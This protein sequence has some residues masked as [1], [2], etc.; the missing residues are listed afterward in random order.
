MAYKTLLEFATDEILFN[1]LAKER[2]K[3]RKRNRD[4]KKPIGQPLIDT[5]LLEDD[6]RQPDGV[7][8][9]SLAPRQGSSVFPEPLQ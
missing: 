5:C 1:L 8:V 4:A 3:Y 9:T 6:F 7:G 2:A